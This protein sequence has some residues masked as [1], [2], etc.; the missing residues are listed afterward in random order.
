[1]GRVLGPLL[2]LSASKTVGGALTY[3]NWRG[4]NTVSVKSTPA[5]PRT[6]DQGEVRSYFSTGG[7]VT[8]SMDT[9]GAIQD[10]LRLQAPSGQSYASYYVREIL[11]SANVNIKAAIADYDVDP[12]QAGL[13]DDA[14]AAAGVE[15]VTLGVLGA[16]D[17]V[18]GE[19]LW[20]AYA[21]SFRLGHDSAS[22]S[23]DSA[24]QADVE[25]FTT[26]L[27]G[28]SFA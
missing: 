14:S 13:F 8:K 10:A 25:G 7:K 26:A 28:H 6:T 27:T 2:S 9:A 19:V 12:I 3:K 23:P 18:P 16:I 17:I 20:A 24:V 11:G 15:G 21:A 4:I 5:N 22:V 1:M